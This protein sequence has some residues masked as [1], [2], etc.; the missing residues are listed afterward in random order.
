MPSSQR[1]R[2]CVHHEAGCSDHEAGCSHHAVIMQ[3]QCRT[4]HGNG[5]GADSG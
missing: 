5:Q 4:T 2:P 1:T 3:L